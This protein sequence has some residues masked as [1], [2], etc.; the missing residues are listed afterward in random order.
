[1]SLHP[2]IVLYLDT[3]IA[4]GHAASF[5]RVD[6]GSMLLQNI[7]VHPDDVT[8]WGDARTRLFYVKVKTKT[9]LNMT[10]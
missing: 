2:Y 7:A 6:G 5:L 3:I 10:I 1:V 4:E 9:N 8:I